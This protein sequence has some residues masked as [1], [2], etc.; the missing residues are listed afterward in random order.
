MENLAKSQ[1]SLH[2]MLGPETVLLHM[3]APPEK[4]RTV[5]LGRGF[6]YRIGYFKDQ[7]S[8]EM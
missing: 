2:H 1:A 8:V 4:V 5:A 3:T 7:K 6:S